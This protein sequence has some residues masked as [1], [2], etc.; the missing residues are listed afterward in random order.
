MITQFIFFPISLT[1]RLI[2]VFSS[3]LLCQSISAFFSQQLS[4]KTIS[5]NKR[6]K[7]LPSQ[8]IPCLT[9][10]LPPLLSYLLSCGYRAP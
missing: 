7:L 4:C 2:E 10:Y 6:Y 1:G 9:L 3:S 8:L 5:Q